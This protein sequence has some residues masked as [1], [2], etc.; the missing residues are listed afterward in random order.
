MIG[1]ITGLLRSW[2]WRRV[3]GHSKP[4]GRG[5][6]VSTPVAEARRAVKHACTFLR[7]PQE[8]SINGPMTGV[9]DFGDCRC[10]YIGAVRAGHGN[11]PG[12]HCVIDGERSASIIIAET[13]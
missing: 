4:P 11:R 3:L 13:V 5:T 6:W 1:G 10:A 8:S 12:R 9:V 7:R 2:W